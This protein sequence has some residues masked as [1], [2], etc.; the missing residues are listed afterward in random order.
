M[1]RALTLLAGA[2]A[3][4][5]TAT[6]LG[7]PVASETPQPEVTLPPIPAIRGLPIPSLPTDLLVPK[8]I[9]APATAQPIAHAPIPQNPWLSPNG[10]NTMHNDAYASDA[11]QVSGPLGKNL[12]VKSASY[13][14]RECATIAFDSHGR[15][16]GL[17]GGLEGFGMMVINPVTLKPISEL[18]TSARDLLTS[19]NPFT[20]IC[21]GTYFF[22]D[23]DDV[24]Y[25][26]TAQKTVLKIKV[27]PNGKLVKEHEWSLAAHVPAEDCLIATMP[28][29]DGR[30]WFFTQ[31]GT[32]GTLDR[33]TGAVEVTR[34]PDGEEV[35][36]SVATDET[37]GMYV[38][39]THALYRL[40][41]TA[42]GAPE[43]TWREVYD[44]GTRLK[45][46]N[47]SQ[48]SG[49]T[50]TLLGDRWVAINDNADP[51]T[52]VLVYD[53]REGATDRLHCTQP[54]LAANA[55]TTDNSL[56]A[57]GSSF[58]IE[59]NYGYKG[60]TS[61]I[62]GK[63]STPGLSRVMVDDNGCHVA[64]TNDSI[65]PSSVAKAS[66]GNGLLYAYTKP[67]GVPVKKNVFDGWYFT[68]IDI[69]T[70]KTV[71]SRLTGTGIQWNN[72]YAAIY[73]GPDGTAYIA[74]L[75]G[76]VRIQDA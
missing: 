31:Q 73:L 75:A 13:G 24:A 71:W 49:T 8:F 25:P 18:R 76:L 17:C 15:I 46:G 53:R 45:P 51:Q 38:V 33:D 40:D 66:L 67:K 42:A 65:A 22:L 61:T 5:L 32:V 64:W 52:N 70:G 2:A 48:G 56:V 63:T 43:V 41:A 21:G 60:P 62:L 74:T 20:D 34:L 57:A 69:Q 14:V 26:T 58:I 7:L 72:H 44:R 16:V 35:T 1:P 19:A 4:V 23:G 39:S 12:R 3:G 11:Y 59:N 68:A 10:T 36:N 47:L 30:I 54:V 28:D 29:W 6:T 55:G 27:Q 50:P 37:G 9:G